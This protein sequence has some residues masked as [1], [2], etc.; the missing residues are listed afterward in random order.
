MIENS[1]WCLKLQVD[2]LSIAFEELNVSRKAKQRSQRPVIGWVTKIYYLELLRA[3]CFGR[4]VKPL[5]L[6]A[7]PVIN[8]RSGFKEG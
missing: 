6:A 4:H 3:R 5:V 2:I 1:N 7:F 8:T